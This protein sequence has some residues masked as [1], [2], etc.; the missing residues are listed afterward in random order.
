MTSL[1]ALAA[2]KLRAHRAQFIGTELDAITL[3][4]AP[5]TSAVNR[6]SAL[7]E[8]FLPAELATALPA[9]Q[10]VR[11]RITGLAPDNT[12]LASTALSAAS[13]EDFH[14]GSSA[15]QAEPVLENTF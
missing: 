15:L 4:T 8:N 7:T 9:N 13:A 12:L 2:A 10:L 14:F 6:T 3:H 5:A 11:I 1:R